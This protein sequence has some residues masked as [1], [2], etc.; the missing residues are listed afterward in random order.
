MKLSTEGAELLYAGASEEATKLIEKMIDQL[1]LDRDRADV[2]S[3]FTA[4]ITGSSLLVG[5]ATDSNLIIESLSTLICAL[6]LQEAERRIA[7]IG[8]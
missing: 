6:A 2:F 4:R 1:E 3:E 8:S 5:L 7:E